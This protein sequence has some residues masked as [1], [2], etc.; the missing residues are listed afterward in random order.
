MVNMK[1]LSFQKCHRMLEVMQTAKAFHSSLD[2]NKLFG[3]VKLWY[4]SG[5]I[6][7]ILSKYF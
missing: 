6:L 7:S 4:V 5:T 1:I 3:A 2:E